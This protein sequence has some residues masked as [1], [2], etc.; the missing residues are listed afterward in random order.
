MSKTKIFALALAALTLGACSSDNDELAGNASV[1]GP[2]QEGFISLNINLPSTSSTRADDNYKF[3]HGDQCE[4]DV[5]NAYLFIFS[6]TNDANEADAVYQYSYKLPIYTPDNGGTNITS[7]FRVTQLITN[8]GTAKLYALVALNLTSKI[9]TIASDIETANKN[10]NVITKIGEKGL[11]RG[12]TKF[13][14]LYGGLMDLTSAS[15]TGDY[16][17]RTNSTDAGFLMFNA[18]LSTVKGG[19]DQPTSNSIVTLAP[20][21]INAIKQSES[22]ASGADDPAA[23]IF[24]ERA[25]AKVTLGTS[26][27]PNGGNANNPYYA[28]LVDWALESTS[29]TSYIVR[30]VSNSDGW[31][32][33]ISTNDASTNTTYRFISDDTELK[34]KN[35]EGTVVDY[36]RTYWGLDPYY[37]G[38]T[39]NITTTKPTLKL[40]GTATTET[41]QYCFENT[42]NIDN[43]QKDQTTGVAVAMKFKPTGIVKDTNDDNDDSN[44]NF[45]FY[46]VNGDKTKMYYA[47]PKEAKNGITTKVLEMFCTVAGITDGK[48]ASGVTIESIF[49]VTMKSEGS[50]D[51][52]IESIKY[53]GSDASWVE[54]SA[55]DDLFD[56][57][58]EMATFVGK[59]N[60]NSFACYKDGLVYYSQ[61]IRHFLDDETGWTAPSTG[62]NAYGEEVANYLGRWGVLR[63]NWYDLS[64]TAIKN[65]GSAELPGPGSGWDDPMESWISVRINILS[66]AKR[67]QD[68]QW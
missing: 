51:S 44:D 42:F 32:N 19:S 63:N 33:L 6:S 59:L 49:Q 24:V 5:K 43:M 23:D 64:V 35:A 30:N 3:D 38:G 55:M 10:G 50:N 40:D 39:T 20:I 47:D 2:G 58:E 26:E 66:W 27:L 9:A 11:E 67:T 8:P 56:T 18:P 37:D 17:N 29:T 57:T 12:T 52:G 4:Y 25:V 61:K 53:N 22:E 14:D 41:P 60:E 45:T 15:I 65:I 16:A 62:S 46:I 7:K 13:S 31:Y 28:E 68:V 21:N 34:A 1:V 48:L 54:G 36:Y